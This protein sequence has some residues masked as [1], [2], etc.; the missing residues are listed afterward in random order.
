MWV[1]VPWLSA[2]RTWDMSLELMLRIGSFHS[3]FYDTLVLM[4]HVFWHIYQHNH[5]RWFCKS[6]RHCIYH[7]CVRNETTSLWF[8]WCQPRRTHSHLTQCTRPSKRSPRSQVSKRS[9]VSSLLMMVLGRTW[10]S[11]FPAYPWTYYIVV[12]RAV[13]NGLP[14]AMHFCFSHPS[15][16]QLKQLFNRCVLHWTLIRQCRQ[17]LLFVTTVSLSNP[18]PAYFQAQTTSEPLSVIDT[19]FAADLMHGIDGTYFF[20]W[21][22]FFFIHYDFT[23]WE[24]TSWNHLSAFPER[25]WHYKSGRFGSSI[26]GTFWSKSLEKHVIRLELWACQ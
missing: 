7:V 18:C 8:L 25:W 24:K 23:D 17:L 6:E 16:F 11:T 14:T 4:I 21:E 13:L 19:S 15:R 20:L 22:T 12:P 5:Y 2:W 1:F 3:L 9:E 26:C 10:Q